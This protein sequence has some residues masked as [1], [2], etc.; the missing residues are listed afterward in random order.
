[1][2]KRSNPGRF[3]WPAALGLVV[4]AL[5]IWWTLHDVHMAEVWD[6]VRGVRWIPFFAAIAVATLTFP[7]RTVRWQYLLRLE[8]ER[9]SFVPLWHAT[10]IG[11]MSTN[12]LPA[13][14]GELARA[15]AAKRLTGTRF[16]T[17]VG[18]I[19]VER[20]FDGIALVAMLAIAMWAGGFG[21]DTAVGSLTLGQIG[22]LAAAAF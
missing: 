21:G 17:A 1:L 12:L 10:A 13:R 20:V 3:G 9:L 11:F 8:G 15:Y 16:T 4:S 2:A 14:T 22:K 5:L 7:L 19:A 18:S 6:R